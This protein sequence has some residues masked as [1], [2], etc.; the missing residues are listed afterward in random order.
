ME[1]LAGITEGKF[2]VE[3]A[4]GTVLIVDLTEA[5]VRRYPG[6]LEARE[7][8]ISNHFENDGLAMTHVTFDPPIR[9]GE[10]IY[11]LCDPPMNWYRSTEVVAITDQK[12]L[13]D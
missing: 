9:V 13:T 7:G 8:T 2:A 5:T 4:S 12:V 6:I 10:K 3:T 1:T 11:M